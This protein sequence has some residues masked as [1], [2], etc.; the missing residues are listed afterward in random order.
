MIDVKLIEEKSI[1]EITPRIALEVTDFQRLA[2]LIDSHVDKNGFLKGILI[3]VEELPGWDDFSA[4]LEHF[5]FVKKHH[6]KI[7][8]V[9]VVTDSPVVSF[10]PNLVDLFVDSDVK[11]FTYED[12]DKATTWLKTGKV[13]Q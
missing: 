6:R 7:Q 5:E 8:R 13:V 12:S 11:H 2:L 10:L 1:L 4:M 9:A 3:H